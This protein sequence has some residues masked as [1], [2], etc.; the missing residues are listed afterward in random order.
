MYRLIEIQDKLLNLIGWHQSYNPDKAIDEKLTETESGLYFQDAHPLVTLDNMAAIIPHDWCFQF[1]LWN[2]TTEYKADTVVRWANDETGKYLN[3]IALVDNV[4]ETP[5]EGSVFWRKYNILSGYLEHLTRN[6]IAT[7][8]QTFIQ[9]KRLEDETRT[10]LERRTLFDGAGRLKATI[11]NRHKLVGFEFMPIRSMGVT[12]KIE[13]I[14]LQ[15]TGGVGNVRLYLFHSSQIEPLKTFDLDFTLT[16][17][18]F[19][20]FTLKDCYLPYISDYNNSG[21]SWYLCYNQDDLPAGMEAVNVA[22][23]FSKDP[24]TS[25]TGYALESWKQLMKYMQVKPFN[26]NAPGTF[27]EFPELWDIQRMTYTN[28]TNYGINCEITIGCDL[29][30]FIIS[31]KQMF[32]TV[33]QRQVAA[34]ALRTLAMNPNVNV[35]RNQ[36]NANRDDILYELDGNTSGVRPNG[37]GYELKK[38]YD[39]LSLDTKGLDRVCLSCNNHGVRYMST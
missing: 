8:I 16:N 18:G 23:D 13:K 36:V 12:T 7:A 9:I 10:L 15:M 38:S 3:W 35:N 19:Q 14:G 29:T 32:Q 2:E 26:I 30:D 24:C 31:Q 37:L 4:G 11:E 25:C 39:A 27:E 21:G 20:W 22:K 34:I 17:G 33:I 6:G 1:P 5:G 28:T